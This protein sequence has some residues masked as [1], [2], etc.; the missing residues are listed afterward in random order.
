MMVIEESDFNIDFEENLNKF[1]INHQPAYQYKYVEETDDYDKMEVEDWSDDDQSENVNVDTTSF[2]T[3]A[4]FFSQANED[5]L[6]RKVAE[7]WFRKDT[8]RKYKRPLQYYRRDRDVSLGD[9]ICWAYLPQVNAYAIRREFGVQYFQYIQDIRSLPWWDVEEFPK[10][11]TL[12][13]LVR[14]HDMPTWGLMKFEAFK[15]FHHRKPHYPKKVKKTDP[16]TGIEET[17]L[18]IK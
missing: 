5:E 13:Y 7:S 11:R 18:K 8:E 15:E 16:V 12:S 6:R 1:D 17:I 2:P 4:E 3:L 9:I 14:V 10:V